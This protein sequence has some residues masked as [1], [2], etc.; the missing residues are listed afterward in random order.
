MRLCPKSEKYASVLNV[1]PGALVCLTFV[2]SCVKNLKNVLS[3]F[4]FGVGIDY[5]PKIESRV[6]SSWVV[7]CWDFLKY[8]D[9][10]CYFFFFVDVYRFA[11][12]VLLITSFLKMSFTF[13]ISVVVQIDKLSKKK[14][15][16]HFRLPL[17][18]IYLYLFT[19]FRQ[20]T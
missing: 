20:W 7:N 1:P 18:V 9:E 6:T 16:L 13:G 17:L 5:N 12:E 15:K 8:L 3:N 10:I 14:K 2:Y 19:L 4:R 11:I